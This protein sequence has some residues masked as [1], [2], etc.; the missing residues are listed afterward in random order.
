MLNG[1]NLVP[2][3]GVL[4]FPSHFSFQACTRPQESTYSCG[5]PHLLHKAHGSC[6]LANNMTLINTLCSQHFEKRA[7]AP[8]KTTSE[9]FLYLFE[10]WDYPRTKI[11]KHGQIQ[12]QSMYVIVPRRHY[13]TRSFRSTG[14]NFRPSWLAMTSTY[15]HTLQKNL[16]SI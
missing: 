13:F 16:T 9:Y 2:F 6:L 5:T 4:T 11:T 1:L 10:P 3:Q 12:L 15:Q 8:C 7:I 14:L